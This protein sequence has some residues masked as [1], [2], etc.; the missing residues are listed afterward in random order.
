M[1]LKVCRCPPWIGLEFGENYF[2][3]YHDLITRARK[4]LER[5]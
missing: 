2:E 5:K 1:E 4:L 3:R